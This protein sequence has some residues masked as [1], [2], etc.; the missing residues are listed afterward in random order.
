[1]NNEQKTAYLYAVIM[2]KFLNLNSLMSIMCV[3]RSSASLY[4]AYAK[5]KLYYR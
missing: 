2:I 3:L 1:M 4:L 5:Q